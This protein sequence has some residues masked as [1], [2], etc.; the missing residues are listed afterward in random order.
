MVRAGEDKGELKVIDNRLLEDGYSTSIPLDHKLRYIWRQLTRSETSLKSS[1][2]SLE[3]LRKQHAEEM[4]EVENY[5][6][7]IRQLSD[8]REDLTKD[9]ESENEQLKAEMEQMKVEREAG[10]VVSEEV[11]DM[12]KDSGMTDISKDTTTIKSQ[13]SHLLKD[14]AAHLDRIKKLE[15]DV[16]SAKDHGGVSQSSKQAKEIVQLERQEMEE[17]MNRLREN[18]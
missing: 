6:T 9:L 8:E 13:V 18:Y 11:C 1:L 17:E 14:R 5:V 10:A 12:L 2:E 3:Q 4:I 7:H 16:E 15:R